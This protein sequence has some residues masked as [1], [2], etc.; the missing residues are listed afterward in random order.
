[1]MPTAGCD[2]GVFPEGQLGTDGVLVGAD[3]G[4]APVLNPYQLVSELPHTIGLTTEGNVGDVL[5][6]D[7][8]VTADGI[9]VGANVGL[10]QVLSPDHLA[11]DLAQTVE[12]T[13]KANLSD[14]LSFDAQFGVASL[15]G[16]HGG[17]DGLPVS[18]DFGEAP[19][20][21]IKST[22]AEVTG[23][24][25]FGDGGSLTAQLVNNVDSDTSASIT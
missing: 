20:H 18:A 15:L 21:L 7:V 13:T 17:P 12:L 3:V 6:F 5:G 11:S 25:L 14:V 8:R 19:S 1:L 23:L 24:Q 16:V 2:S 9:F 22:L 10:S 4:L